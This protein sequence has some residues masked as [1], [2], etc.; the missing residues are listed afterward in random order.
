MSGAEYEALSAN[1]RRLTDANIVAD[2]RARLATTMHL[3]PDEQVVE[4]MEEAATAT[5]KIAHLVANLL[6][7]ADKDDQS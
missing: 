5:D 4:E 6:P 1:Q 3:P 7:I 2:A